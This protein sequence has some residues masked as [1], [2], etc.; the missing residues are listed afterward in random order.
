[1][2]YAYKIWKIALKRHN[3]KVTGL[4]E[5]VEKETEVESFF[6]EIIAEYFSNL[7]KPEESR[8]TNFSRNP[9]SQKRVE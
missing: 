8:M 4:K 3:Q 2:K 7:E 6:K 9:A 5:D 1:M